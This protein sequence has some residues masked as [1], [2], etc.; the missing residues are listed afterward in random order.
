MWFHL[1]F[2]DV[3]CLCLGLICFFLDYLFGRLCVGLF[4]FVRKRFDLFG[5]GF[6]DILC[7]FVYSRSFTH[8]SVPRQEME[9]GL[10]VIISE[11]DFFVV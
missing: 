1:A 7:E 4:T 6:F 5:V 10:I 3:V 9:N 8:E 11:D 2:V